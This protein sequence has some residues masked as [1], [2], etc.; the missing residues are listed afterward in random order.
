MQVIHQSMAITVN[1]EIISL[2]LRE[3]KRFEVKAVC[4]AIF[5][6]DE[7]ASISQI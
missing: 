6:D 4:R 2:L 7:I 5:K 3:E 1:S